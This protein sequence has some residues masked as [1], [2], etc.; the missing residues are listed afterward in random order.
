MRENEG[1]KKELDLMER[2]VRTTHLLLA[3]YKLSAW[4]AR[5]AG[6]RS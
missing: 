1:M 3:F 4:D 2:T 5:I 6:R